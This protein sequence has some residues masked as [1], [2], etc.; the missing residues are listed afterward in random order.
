MPCLVIPSLFPS[1]EKAHLWVIINPKEHLDTWEVTVLLELPSRSYRIWS[2]METILQLFS[3]SYHLHCLLLCNKLLQKLS[4]LGNQWLVISHDPVGQWDLVGWPLPVPGG[5][6]CAASLCQELGWNRGIQDGL[7]PS[8]AVSELSSVAWV[9]TGQLIP[10][11]GLELP[12]SA[13]PHSVGPR[14][15]Q[16]PMLEPTLKQRGHS[17]HL[18]YILVTYFQSMC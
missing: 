5:V 16:G 3:L 15:S 9:F 12:E 18:Q 10:R 4:Y 17:L 1:P 11:W 2:T 8:I 7:P 6:F 13:L 14:E